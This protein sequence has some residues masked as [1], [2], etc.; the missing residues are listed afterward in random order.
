M[1]IIDFDEKYIEDIILIENCSHIK[2][3]NKEMFLNSCKNKF[4]S[5]KVILE[6]HTVAGY[7]IYSVIADE[8]E[9]LNITVAPKYRRQSFAKK[10]LEYVEQK[11]A[12]SKV[13]NIF[14]EVRESNSAAIN[15]YLS[16][17]FKQFGSR[18][19][20]YGSEDAKLLRKII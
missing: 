12:Q 19:K 15:L 10:M 17:G 8:A 3:W 1:N 20:Y 11:A 18:T 5:F 14:L 2:P 7:C 4:V 13:K 16:L 9:I 6:N